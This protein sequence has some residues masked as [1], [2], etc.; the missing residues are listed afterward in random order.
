MPCA[1]KP[2][3]GSGYPSVMSIETKMPRTEKRPTLLII[4]LTEFSAR[5]R[6]VSLPVYF[7]YGKV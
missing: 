1:G 3:M 6:K 7:L 2:G 5:A 4:F